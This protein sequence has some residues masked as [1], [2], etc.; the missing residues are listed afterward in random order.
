MPK[1]LKICLY[2]SLLAVLLC[3]AIF[4][5]EPAARADFY[6]YK[7]EKGVVCITDNRDAVPP[8][9]RATM[10]VITDEHLSTQAGKGS[11]PSPP[12]VSPALR[13][14]SP[15]ATDQ[16]ATPDQPVSRFTRLLAHYQWVKP[17]LILAG[18]VAAFLAV[19]R[20]TALIPS[21]Q[22]S[23]LILVVFF[24]GTFVFVYKTY[25][26][27]LVDS[28]FTVKN[29]MVGMFSSVGKPGAPAVVKPLPE[30]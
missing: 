13:D 29:R 23:R 14:P 17:L 27:Y 21:P 30:P 1:Q 19:T 12:A 3:A 22:L 18:I 11:A 25:A 24:L 7:N 20:L 9:F 15:S 2:I 28:Y 16:E 6:K 10:K 8:K 4:G 26:E 5:N